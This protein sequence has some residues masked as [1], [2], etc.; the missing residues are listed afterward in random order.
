MW[1]I[2]WG[3]DAQVE[4]P[5]IVVVFKSRGDESVEV[6]AKSSLQCKISH[7]REG[8]KHRCAELD[9]MGWSRTR[10]V[11]TACRDGYPAEDANTSVECSVTTNRHQVL[12][13]LA[14]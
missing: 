2:G 6:V 9:M 7:K 5:Q 3:G 11:N 10:V 14:R 1:S 4:P 12:G 8:R 13:V